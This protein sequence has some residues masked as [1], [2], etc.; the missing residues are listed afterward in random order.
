MARLSLP[1]A[2]S[3]SMAMVFVVMSLFVAVMVNTSLPSQPVQSDAPLGR[4]PS[5]A[6][7]MSLIQGKI[8]VDPP[9]FQP[10]EQSQPHHSVAMERPTLTETRAKEISIL[11]KDADDV[12]H[13]SR[14]HQTKAKS[15]PPDVALT[16]FST[17]NQFAASLRTKLQFATLHLADRMGVK[18]SS[19]VVIGLVV[20]FIL[21]LCSLS[22][23]VFSFPFRLRGQQGSGGANGQSPK[24]IATV[25][26]QRERMLAHTSPLQGGNRYARAV[27]ASTGSAAGS[28]PFLNAE[29]SRSGGIMPAPRDISHASEVAPSPRQSITE[30]HHRQT[31]KPPPLC[32]TLVMP[33][34]EALLGI[35]MYELA[36][37][38]A[39]GELNIVG[40][41][42]KPLLRAVVKKVGNARTL[43]V[44][45]PEQNSIPRAT[46][47]PSEAAPEGANG[48]RALEIRAM[49]GAFY[50]TL[51]MRSSGACYVVK[52]G[53]TVLT[54]DGDAESLQLSL[55]S[56]VGLQLASVRC[57]TE[58]FDGVDHVEIRVEP[59]VDTVLVVAVVLAV[60]LLS[61]YLPPVD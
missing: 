3:V 12:S 5:P 59:G 34:S 16:S 49:R 8:L 20:A 52:D 45:M 53:Q 44:S 24:D 47:A 2:T 19:V 1:Q 43:E 27:G 21:V 25:L 61:P 17:N 18:S 51:E 13:L 58:L 29:P 36:Q 4:A 11:T 37:L 10:Q 23:L 39:E 40:I 50:G 14:P 9:Q 57:S 6:D 55:K 41:S 28:Q 30:Q 7:L 31:A 32:P 22:S 33:M 15:K 35:Q 56:S 38:S 48:S 54:I 46:I 26:E 60:L 42:G